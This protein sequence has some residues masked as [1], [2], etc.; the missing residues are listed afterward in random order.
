MLPNPDYLLS[1]LD[2][3]TPLIGFYD[4]A[5]F[6]MF[7]PIVT[8]NRCLFAAYDNW[9]NGESIC[10]SKGNNSCRGGGYWIG[11]TEFTSRTQFANTLF[12]KEG[13]KS[14]PEIMEEWLVSQKPY[15]IKKNYVV[16]SKLI[17]ELYSDLQTVTFFVTI[18]QLSLLMI[19]ADYHS[20]SPNNNLVKHFFGSG[21]CQ[22]AAVFNDCPAD[23]PQAFIG[24]TDIAMRQYLPQNIIAFTVNK[25]MYEQLCNLDENCFLN[26]PFLRRLKSVRSDTL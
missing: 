13:F 6:S 26:K 10:L 17:N 21:C 14:S 23:K 25:P 9:K 5:D 4:V 3:D 11:N 12:E 20:G 1:C 19:G 15:E 18:D 2:L 24:G 22:M 16:I 8:T 7:E